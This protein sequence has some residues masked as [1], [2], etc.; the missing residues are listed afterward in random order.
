MTGVI[1]RTLQCYNRGHKA[2]IQDTRLPSQSPL[3]AQHLPLL[4]NPLDTD[5][6]NGE[7]CQER[8]KY[9]YQVGHILMLDKKC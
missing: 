6:Q 1:R 5:D 9:F 2:A 3:T 8:P 7:K 4:Q